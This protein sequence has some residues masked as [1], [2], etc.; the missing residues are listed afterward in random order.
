MKDRPQDVFVFIVGGTT[1]EESKAVEEFNEAFP[2]MRVTLGGT[3]W[4]KEKRHPTLGDEVV[5]GA[6]AKPD[7]WSLGALPYKLPQGIYTLDVECVD[8]AAGGGVSLGWALGA[9]QFTRYK[10]AG[11][12]PAQLLVAEENV[13]ADARRLA[14]AT[15]LVRD[16]INMPANDMGP[17]ELTAVAEEVAAAG[18]ASVDVILGENLAVST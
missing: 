16:L 15:Y 2:G 12:P 8:V 6:G 18:G 13:L 3:S 4:R 5:V 1:Y 10:T 17:A 7:F 14:S 9:Y 11:R